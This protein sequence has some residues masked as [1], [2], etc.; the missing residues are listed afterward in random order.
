VARK[1]PIRNLLPLNTNRENPYPAKAP[2]NVERMAVP[3]EIIVLF[4]K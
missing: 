3:K 1:K 4:K 2:K